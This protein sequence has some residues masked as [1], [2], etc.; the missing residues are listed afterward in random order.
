[1]KCLTLAVA[2]FVW[3]FSYGQIISMFTWDDAGNPTTQAD[4]GP[5]ATSISGSAIIDAGGTGGTTGLNAGLPKANINMVLPGSPTFDVPGIDVSFDFQREESSG[6]WFDR[7]SFLRLDGCNNLAVTYRVDDGGGGFTEISS[8]NVFAIPN[9]DT[10]RNYRFYYL[11]TSGYGALLVD[12]VEV[13]N[14]DGPDNRDMYWT[15]AGNIIIGNGLDGTGNNDTFLDNLIIGNV[16]STALP[17]ELVRFSA[18]PVQEAVQLNWTTKSEQNNAFF[19]IERSKNGLGWEFVTE[20]EGAG[21]S[22]TK[23]D[24]ETIDQRPYLGLSYYRLKQTDFNGDYS[25]SDIVSV[26][27]EGPSELIVYPNPSSGGQFS[28][29]LEGLR[30]EDVQ[31]VDVSGRKVAY[32]L[33]ASDQG[34]VIDVSEVPVG[35]Y[36]LNVLTSGQS[37]SHRVLIE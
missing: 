21:D 13:W 34:T 20:V 23:I 32:S 3:T 19:T 18:N 11:P 31:L 9:D 4:I 14:N 22:S 36:F 5:D 10:Y 1:M 25:Y 12:G 26:F 24:Y 8:G 37:L 28:I 29:N 30:E 15:G 16:T 2:L 17:I 7:G 6:D 35:V 27:L 33:H